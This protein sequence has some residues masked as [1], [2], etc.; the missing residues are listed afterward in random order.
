MGTTTFPT[1]QKV[2]LYEFDGILHEK[3]NERDGKVR[4]DAIRA[5]LNGRLAWF[6]DVYFGQQTA[7]HRKTVAERG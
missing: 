5:V 3:L 7:E 2:V 1:A 4:P 6:V